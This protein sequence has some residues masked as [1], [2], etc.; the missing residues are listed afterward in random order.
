MAT[1]EA[2]IGEPCAKLKSS[3]DWGERGARGCSWWSCLSSPWSIGVCSLL[4]PPLVGVDLCSRCRFVLAPD[5]VTVRQQPHSHHAR[6]A[7]TSRVVA[8]LDLGGCNHAMMT[9]WSWLLSL[10]SIGCS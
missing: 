6:N 1:G 5:F 4:L 2:K 9:W 7:T 3:A 8:A 10:W